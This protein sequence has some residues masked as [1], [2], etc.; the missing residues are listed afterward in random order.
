MYCTVW[1]VGVCGLVYALLA[2]TC[3][4]QQRLLQLADLQLGVTSWQRQNHIVN[5]LACYL[6]AGLL[7]LDIGVHARSALQQVLSC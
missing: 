7:C 5:L 1:S 3:A 4:W 6:R 2:E